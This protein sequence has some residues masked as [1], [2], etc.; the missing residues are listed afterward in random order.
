MGSTNDTGALTS[1]RS[2]AGVGSAGVSLEQK[3]P[4]TRPFS[5]HPGSLVK[6]QPGCFDFRQFIERP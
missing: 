6:L 2:D 4:I 1:R 5:L 3:I